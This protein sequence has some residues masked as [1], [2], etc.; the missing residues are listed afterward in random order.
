L[1]ELSKKRFTA[2]TI[3]KCLRA[4]LSRNIKEGKLFHGTQA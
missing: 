1:N 3:S 4:Y 2:E